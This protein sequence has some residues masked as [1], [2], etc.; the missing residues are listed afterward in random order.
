MVAIG[1]AIHERLASH[2]GVSAKVGSRVFPK[3]PPQ[4][5][6]SPFV[7]YELVSAPRES[8]MGRDTDS[9]PVFQITAWA[10]S[11][12][13]AVATATEVKNALSRFH[14][15]VTVDGSDFEI[16]SGFVQ[17]EIDRFDDDVE[18]EGRQV[19]IEITHGV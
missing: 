10:S 9:R 19:D 3:R 1:E 16:K 8:A 2:A 5:P 17:A 12:A 14:G 6:S 7:V 18:L 4:A 11:H 13:E 15:T